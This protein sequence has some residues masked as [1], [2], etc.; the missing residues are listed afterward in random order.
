MGCSDYWIDGEIL[1]TDLYVELERREEDSSS[2][3]AVDGGLVASPR[4]LSPGLKSKLQPQ[5][6]YLAL[7][8]ADR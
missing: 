4:S 8:E 7:A 6:V 2:V 3:L 5:R 1:L